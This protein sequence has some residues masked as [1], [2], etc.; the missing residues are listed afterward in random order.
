MLSAWRPAANVKPQRVL[1]STHVSQ[2][3]PLSSRS[4][5]SP[6]ASL[7][8]CLKMD[9]V[10]IP[11]AVAHSNMKRL[12]LMTGL[13]PTNDRFHADI[14]NAFRQSNDNIIKFEFLSPQHQMFERPEKVALKPNVGILRKSWIEKY[15]ARRPAV[16]LIFMDLEWDDPNFAEKKTECESKINSLRQTVGCAEVR[17]LLV[18]IQK[19]TSHGSQTERINELCSVCGLTSH[20]LR[21]L[22]VAEGIKPQVVL[23]IKKTVSELSQQFYEAIIKKI[24]TRRVPENHLN[25]MIK[26]NFKLGFISELRSD[27][28]YAMN[29][30]RSAFEKYHEAK[31]PDEDKYEYLTVASIIN[32]KICEMF[33]SRGNAIEA[34]TQFNRH[35]DRFMNKHKYSHGS[36]PT[37]ALAAI[38]HTLWC[39]KEYATFG[40]LFVE[41]ANAVV[42]NSSVNPG[43]Y[44]SAAAEYS[45]LANTLIE[46]LK[47]A[48]PNPAPANLD[49]LQPPSP[50]VFLGQ[51][52]WRPNVSTADVTTEH[53][54]R[55]A[56]EGSSKLDYERSIIYLRRALLH[57][58]RIERCSRQMRVA[59]LQVA[60]VLTKQ[61][62]F[63]GALP[64][65][66]T[67]FRM[68]QEDNSQHFFIPIYTLLY[69]L[70]F[71]VVDPVKFVQII[72][73][74]M[75][76]EVTRS[77]ACKQV[78]GTLKESTAH[79]LNCFNCIC[80][81]QPPP[82]L[83]TVLKSLSQ[84]D[85]EQLML[86]WTQAVRTP[87]RV[88]AMDTILSA[89]GSII[90][91]SEIISNEADAFC[92]VHIT[93]KFSDTIVIAA[94]NFIVD[95]YS[96]AVTPQ[97]P[98]EFFTHT[99]G[100]FVIKPEQVAAIPFPLKPIPA[101]FNLD[102]EV[103]LARIDLLI[104]NNVT[105]FFDNRHFTINRFNNPIQK[106][107][108][109]IRIIRTDYPLVVQRSVPPVSGGDIVL[110]GE[111]ADL[112][113]VVDNN[114]G[115]GF[116]DIRL[117]CKAVATDDGVVGKFV[118]DQHPEGVSTAEFTYQSLAPGTSLTVPFYGFYSV[119]G[120]HTVDVE[121][122]AT[123]ESPEPT[124]FKKRYDIELSVCEPFEYR[125]R[126][127]D[128]EGSVV[129]CFFKQE[130]GQLEVHLRALANCIVTGYEF[131][132]GELGA[133]QG[134]SITTDMDA[135]DSIVVN[136]IVSPRES[137]VIN[138]VVGAG[139]IRVTWKR[140][141]RSVQSVTE[142][143][144]GQVTVVQSPILMAVEV[145]EGEHVIHRDINIQ[146]SV[147]NL[148]EAP[149]LLKLNIERDDMF[150]FA[151]TTEVPILLEPGQTHMRTFTFAANVAGELTF[152]K[153]T[154][155]CP[156]DVNG[157]IAQYIPK[158]LPKTILVLPAS[159]VI[160]IPYGT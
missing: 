46:R 109:S 67:V 33:F 59:E 86:R 110:K 96:P 136:A 50:L 57:L 133:S 29:C 107:R 126:V 118:S 39:M 66:E 11:V 112:T 129:D 101:A 149:M 56:L 53:R 158:V 83:P 144:L 64:I 82:L 3:F 48:N 73:Q 38:E 20:H 146:C 94:A 88:T 145:S 123:L 119:V 72:L 117:V 75:N 103:T 122:T 65:A 76:P 127:L 137:S 60:N 24:R 1:R 6:V 124:H 41:A 87:I 95:I 36:Y 99:R 147:K 44:F 5:P 115:F 21:V 42:L 8:S 34:V 28:T 61:H 92:M 30:Y 134:E 156:D 132:L 37:D 27:L 14:A 74:M 105:L 10:D 54:A 13:D 15:T 25:L 152:P 12:F 128:A 138:A 121:F 80:Y 19:K 157:I 18:L 93:N 51:R 160:D 98:V 89:E 58:R 9:A 104:G 142:Y 159:K 2:P 106:P 63:D 151:G 70:Y 139:K 16:I 62:N 17:F 113:F 84:S 31:V 130:E 102:C 91:D 52:P 131:T 40:H 148:L 143:D 154:I 135:G 108:Q 125:R 68:M 120:R 97:G 155:E 79:F 69:E 100:N 78:F 45:E 77:T 71:A 85:R 4:S 7:P 22:Y 32:F 111:V 116:S 141:E 35:E 81:Q 150:M 43:K 23:S 47:A 140:D 114:G 26:N 49:I 153:I 90:A 55:V